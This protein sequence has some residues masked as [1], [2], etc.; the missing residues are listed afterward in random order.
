MSQYP[1]DVLNLGNEDEPDY[2]EVMRAL[3]HRPFLV[4]KKDFREDARLFIPGDELSDAINT[5]I[6]VGDPLL[7]TGDPGVGKTQTAYYVAYRIGSEPVIP[8]QVKSDTKAV[9][10]LYQFDMIRYYGDAHAGGSTTM[11]KKEEYITEG[12]LWRAIKS[13][14]ENKL[15]QVLLIDEIDK[16]PRDF[17]NDLLLELD[18]MELEVR[19]T[20]QRIEAEKP[21]RPVVVITSNS[22]RRLPE[23]FLRRCVYHHIRF[24][25]Q[26]L[27]RAVA[28]RRQYFKRLSNEFIDLA[29]KRFLELREE[30]ARKR[31]A[32]A[33][34]LVWLT[35]LAAEQGETVGRLEDR[36]RGSGF[37]DLPH[38]SAIIKDRTDFERL[39]KKNI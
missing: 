3:A 14:N 4:S 39:Q 10:L 36:L 2:G 9:D 24:D 6:A 31:P 21:Y 26:V 23:P 17:P 33:E 12:P 13:G 27:R 34:L 16:A 11:K 29:I 30:C 18:K 25:E 22:E 7:L 8:F 35:V 37:T 19:E 1:F 5:A 32:T 28:V 38:L 15:P 20:N